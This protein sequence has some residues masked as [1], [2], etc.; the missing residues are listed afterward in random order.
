MI[1]FPGHQFNSEIV[2]TLM[3]LVHQET[4]R[5][6]DI[7]FFKKD[8]SENLTILELHQLNAPEFAVI[9][10]IVNEVGGL[11]TEED[12]QEFAATLAP[13]SSAGVIL[14]EHTWAAH[15]RNAIQD[16]QGNIVLNSRISQSVVVKRVLD[17][18]ISVLRGFG[19]QYSSELSGDPHFA[20]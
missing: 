13:N 11:L 4:I 17:G 8:R 9:E 15:L 10:A 12:I 2:S 5:I 3:D 14:F 19:E 1:Q 18:E 16:R 7:I 6:I 20:P